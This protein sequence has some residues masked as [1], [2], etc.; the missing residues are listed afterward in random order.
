MPRLEVEVSPRKYNK[1]ARVPVGT[2]AYFMWSRTILLGMPI[3]RNR[4][5]LDPATRLRSMQLRF[6]VYLVT[7]SI[8]I[9][10]MA[11]LAANAVMHE[12]YRQNAGTQQVTA[13]VTSTKQDCTRSGCGYDSYGTYAIYGKQEQNVKVAWHTNVPVTDPVPVLVNPRR[14][15]M[16]MP[17]YFNPYPAQAILSAGFAGA[18]ALWDTL[19]YFFYRRT[20]KRLAANI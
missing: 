6:R 11:G 20:R 18:F 9:L 12:F 17:Y 7:T 16:A 15:R 1:Y 5:Q 4:P 3:K 2:A 19:L 8:L 10:V 14:P 13:T